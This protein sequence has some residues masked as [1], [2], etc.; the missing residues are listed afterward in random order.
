MRERVMEDR[1]IPGRPAE[2]GADARSRAE[3]PATP[4]I[5]PSEQL[6]DTPYPLHDGPSPTIGWQFRPVGKGGPAF[7]I[8][9]RGA[10]GSLKVVE[11]FPLTDD[12]WTR[13]WRS[14]SSLNPRA[15]P[16][17]LG[18]LAVRQA[19][20]LSQVESSQVRELEA[21][22]LAVM[23]DV[24]YLGGYIQGS[25]LRAGERYDVW[26]HED[27][28]TVTALRRPVVLAEVPYSEV[29]DVEIGGPGLV[30]TGG[31]FVGGGFGASAALEGMAI[32]AV[33]N[34]LTTRTSIKSIVRIQGMSCE[35]FMLHTTV[36]PEQLRIGLSRPLAAIR[37][38]HRPKVSGGSHQ[39][40]PAAESS[41]AELAKLADMLEKGLLTRDEF[42]FMKAKLLGKDT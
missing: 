32:A 20:G 22:S 14:F 24:A 4:V 13:A 18:A 27:G 16:R 37:T 42:D 5:G 39:G 12:G 35:L 28:L 1:D 3:V 41:V 31:G 38:G 9:R 36:T 40:P 6:R 29:E 25:E 23:R 17:V 26:F 2:H 34:T 8:I 19:E 11:A 33:L 15:V 10:L 7:V 30:R 21:R